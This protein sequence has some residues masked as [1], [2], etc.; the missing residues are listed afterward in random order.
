M[1]IGELAQRSGL[2]PSRLRFYESAGLI[3]PAD[4]GTNGYR[5]FPAET[6][7][8]LELI[9]GAQ[10]AGFTLD[11]IRGLLPGCDNDAIGHGPQIAEAL[12]RKVGEIEALQQR[13]ETSRARLL[14]IIDSLE[15]G[16]Q[17]LGCAANT[18]RVL[19]EIKLTDIKETAAKEA[20]E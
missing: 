1:R 10:R 7:T 12:R 17:D 19:A 5:A 14:A 4:R 2:S 15:N 11:E 6:L 3:G 9:T 18:R 20:A 16:P 13:L 8:R